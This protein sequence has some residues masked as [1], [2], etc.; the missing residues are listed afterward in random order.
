[1]RWRLKDRTDDNCD[2]CGQKET[3]HH[4][5]SHCPTALNNGKYTWRHNNV[6]KIITEFLFDHLSKKGIKILA[7]LA[8]KPYSYSAFPPHI[9][10]TQLRPDII[11]MDDEK[12]P[13]RISLIELTCPDDEGSGEA[14]QRKMQKYLPL[15]E[16][17]RRKKI[18]CDI[19]PV[20][21]TTRGRVLRSLPMAIEKV[22]SNHGITLPKLS[23]KNM[24][25]S[26]SYMALNC[27]FVIYI[28]RRSSSFHDIPSELPHKQ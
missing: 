4:I 18:E 28:T 16:E 12:S 21:V 23:L 10:S 15:K 24:L 7:D 27:S 5:L 19:L 22:M 11:I 3:V 8:D 17:L 26:V 14:Y 6:L 13:K 20:E 2:T 1:M 9:L 25:S